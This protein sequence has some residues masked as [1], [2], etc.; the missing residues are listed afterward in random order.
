MNSSLIFF[1]SYLQ[2]SFK[3]R[4]MV[5]P[6]TTSDF[7]GI[8]FACNLG[9]KRVP[10][11]LAVSLLRDCIYPSKLHYST[12]KVLLCIRL[13]NYLIKGLLDVFKLTTVHFE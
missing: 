3:K 1:K 4:V 6:P 7:R 8:M 12:G 13:Q 10:A 2:Y 9:K 5:L 11:W